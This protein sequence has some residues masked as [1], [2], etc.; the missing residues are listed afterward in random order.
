[1]PAPDQCADAAEIPSAGRGFRWGWLLFVAVAAPLLAGA[2]VVIRDLRLAADITECRE[3]LRRI[4]LALHAYHDE[5]QA[6]PPAHVRGPDGK[7]WHSWRVLILPY[8]GEEELYRHYRFDEP[9][10]GPHNR[11]LTPRVPTVLACAA[12]N[13]GSGRTS[14]FAVVSPRTMW[15]AHRSLTFMDVMDGTS[16]TIHVV[17]DV[18]TDVVWTQPRD[19]SPLELRENLRTQASPHHR[20]TAEHGRNMLFVDGNVRY[21]ALHADPS[22]L[23]SL[24]TPAFGREWVTAEDW[25][26]DL[27]GD[28]PPLD[29]GPMRNAVQLPATDISA[30]RDAELPAGKTVLW[31]ATFQMVWD[32]LRGRLQVDSVPFES[33]P[34]LAAT[35]DAWHYPRE[36]LSHDCYTLMVDGVEPGAADRVAARVREQIPGADSHPSSKTAPDGFRVYTYLEK[37]MPFAQEFE[38]LADGAAFRTEKGEA[39]VAAFGVVPE[40]GYGLGTPVFAKQV[41]ILDYVNDEDFIV[42]LTTNGPQRDRVLLAKIEPES[43][44]RRTWEAVQSRIDSPHQWH[45]RP[46]LMSVEPLVAPVLLFNLRRD[47]EELIGATLDL[48]NSFL[49]GYYIDE[50]WQNIR[51]RLDERGA[52]F[53]SEAEVMIVG[54][55]GD[56]DA[57]GPPPPRPRRFVFDRPFLIVL[58]EEQAVEP[59]FIG[60][61]G[62]ADLMEREEER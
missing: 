14:Y 19:V 34:P 2:A 30:V 45:D 3:N 47:F 58:R 21:V 24:L 17:E 28:P 29:F 46:H 35:L 37:R 25:P 43:T 31:C 38:R 12:A 5:H 53:V 7:L 8:L 10:D 16:N 13:A 26:T 61:I 50:A 39:P 36:A 56:T 49:D 59:Y 44:L 51:L 57:P 11:E 4:G 22:L 27:A 40:K 6:F 55:F 15:P 54:E 9:W 32:E 62:N 48:P 52:D 42:E 1:M 60:W 41:R 23:P 33:Q 20:T 18:L